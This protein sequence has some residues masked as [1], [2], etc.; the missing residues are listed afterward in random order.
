MNM[1]FANNQDEVQRAELREMVLKS[2]D[3]AEKMQKLVTLSNEAIQRNAST[4]GVFSSSVADQVASNT[5]R[6]IQ[7]VEQS[8]SLA[9]TQQLVSEFSFW[10]NHVQEM[11]ATKMIHMTE[12]FGGSLPD[13]L[14]TQVRVLD[15][16]KNNLQETRTRQLQSLERKEQLLRAARL[17]EQTI[18]EPSQVAATEAVVQAPAVSPTRQ[19]IGDSQTQTGELATQ[20]QQ[21]DPQA[22]PPKIETADLGEE[23][24]VVSDDLS[25]ESSSVVTTDVDQVTTA[26]AEEAEDSQAGETGDLQTQTGE[27]A[28]Q[29]QQAD[30]QAASEQPDTLEQ[31]AADL[32]TELADIDTAAQTDLTQDVSDTAA[33]ASPSA[34]SQGSQIIRDLQKEIGDLRKE[35]QDL[36][37]AKVEPIL[38]AQTLAEAD[39]AAD[40]AFSGDP[41]RAETFKDKL[42]RT[43]D[44]LTIDTPIDFLIKLN[45]NSSVDTFLEF[46]KSPVNYRGRTGET[47]KFGTTEVDGK[48]VETIPLPYFREKFKDVNAIG[49]ALSRS[50]KK[51]DPEWAAKP[52][53]S[54]KLYEIGKGD[55]SKEAVKEVITKMFSELLLNNARS[56]ENIKKFKLHFGTELMNNGKEQFLN[57]ASFSFM[58]DLLMN[59]A[60]KLDSFWNI[61]S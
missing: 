14:Q 38:K 49:G 6:F 23:V 32:D 11:I 55:A 30:L 47:L 15:D 3:A 42:R 50:A 35:F 58:I 21:A 61:A 56:E 46:L 10:I 54:E 9:D 33:E 34:D 19:E 29:E 48:Q 44:E 59:K 7:N 37:A 4:E 41:Q 52:E 24:L 16:V 36:I 18:D 1:D 17:A 22:A 43:L 39:A 40:D 45:E 31:V 20:E 12:Y 8:Q 2:Q 27:P 25:E 51:I 28:T 57:T 26:S 13:T 53:N 5:A 60:E